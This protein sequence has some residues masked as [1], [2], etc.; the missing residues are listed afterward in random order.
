M[1]TQR[2]HKLNNK[3]M[4][5]WEIWLFHIVWGFKAFLK[6]PVIF[7]NRVAENNALGTIYINIYI[8]LGGG[9]TWYMV[10]LPFSCSLLIKTKKLK[11]HDLY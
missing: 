2:F 11:E 1:M 6:A 7:I 8:I 5:L 10:H 9:F 4:H 3:L